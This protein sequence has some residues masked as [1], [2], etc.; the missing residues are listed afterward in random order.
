[1]II[2]H[3]RWAQR[4]KS[5]QSTQ[6]YLKFPEVENKRS[7]TFPSQSSTNTNAHDQELHCATETG[8]RHFS[9][10]DFKVSKFSDP[11][12]STGENNHTVLLQKCFTQVKRRGSIHFHYKAT[13]KQMHKRV[14]L[15]FYRFLRQKEPLQISP[16]SRTSP[17]EVAAA[18]A[19]FPT[20]TL[21]STNLTSTRK[22]AP[23]TNTIWR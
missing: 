23:L 6:V 20:T 5:I 13:R 12:T 11:Q 22:H 7:H 21:V 10:D 17:H 14:A 3:K 16:S 8:S 1:M 9:H 19:A 4:E 18:A 15:L 2:A